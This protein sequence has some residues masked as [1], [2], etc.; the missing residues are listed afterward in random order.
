MLK[1]GSQTS[2]TQRREALSV[3]TA[4]LRKSGGGNVTSADLSNIE[5][6][7]DDSDSGVR[8]DVAELL[9]F[10]PDDIFNRLT[11]QLLNDNN[12]YVRRAAERSKARRR[13][14]HHES[15]RA[16]RGL[17]AFHD[18]HKQF[19]L[20]FGEPAAK[21][22]LSLGQQH[23][24]LVCAG[25]AH[26]LLG[27]LASIKAHA[28]T[29]GAAR[30]RK[31]TEAQTARR[32]LK[33]NIDLMEGALK[34]LL[35]YSKRVELNLSSEHLPETIAQ[36]KEHA[37]RALKAQGMKIKAITVQLEAIPDTHLE[38]TLHLIVTALGNLIKNAC[39]SFQ[40]KDGTVHS[41]VVTIAALERVDHVEI[42]IHNTGKGLSPEKLQAV[43][44]WMP[45]HRNPLKQTSRGY[46]RL[47]AKV[48][49]EAHGGTLDYQSAPG[50]GVTAVVTLPI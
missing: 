34:D 28:S 35:S 13:N 37:F 20:R 8:Q 18:A 21:D 45:G 26:D 30:T 46:G 49:I 23:V 12:A 9:V 31:S 27:I 42:R 44:T 25:A 14:A 32:Q 29:A 38:I 22:A 6:L 33:F 24:E 10:L 19:I 50:Q 11:G 1:I 2:V 7:A 39:E 4:D 17:D 40:S 5:T 16:Q 36:A 41:G 43:R 47:Q 15:R 3:F 48:N